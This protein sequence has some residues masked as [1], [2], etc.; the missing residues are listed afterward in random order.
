MTPS[1]KRAARKAALK[2]LRPGFDDNISGDFQRQLN[3]LI[4]EYAR[5][6]KMTVAQIIGVLECVKLDMWSEATEDDV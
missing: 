2:V 1:Q 4:D 3:D 6:L 5:P